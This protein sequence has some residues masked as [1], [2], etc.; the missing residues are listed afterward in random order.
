MT[1]DEKAAA[2]AIRYRDG[3]FSETV[4]RASLFAIG[5]RGDAIRTI[6]QEATMA[7]KTTTEEFTE[8]LM[9]L[10]QKHYPR[11]LKGDIEQ[12]SQL[13]SDLAVAT[14]AV[15]AFAFKL[16]GQVIGRGAMHTIFQ[17]IVENAT[18]IDPAAGA[19]VRKSLPSI[20]N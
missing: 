16:N 18:A 15:M 17:R 7:K 14:G 20:A 10:I 11:A 6:I 13:G 19:M 1:R 4:Y 12:N 3:E 8:D 5:Y 2:L 9:G